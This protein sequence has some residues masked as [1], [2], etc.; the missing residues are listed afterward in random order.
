[1]II[2]DAIHYLGPIMLVAEMQLVIR[3]KILLTLK[4]VDK[5][6]FN[7]LHFE[8]TGYLLFGDIHDVLCF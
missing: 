7:R 4:I 2:E 3:Q 8:N 6:Q 5:P 1:M